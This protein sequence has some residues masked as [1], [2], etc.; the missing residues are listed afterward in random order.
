MLINLLLKPIIDHFN[1]PFEKRI[2]S[3]ARVENRFR[4]EGPETDVHW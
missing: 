4:T 1:A 3:P 2:V